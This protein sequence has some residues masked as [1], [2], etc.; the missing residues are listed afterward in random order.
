MSTFGNVVW[1]I[2]G[3][4]GTAVGYITVGLGYCVT[5]VGIP[6]GIQAIKLGIATLLP[7]GI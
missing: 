7:F 4:L 1:L 6:W 3:G 2:F 5:V